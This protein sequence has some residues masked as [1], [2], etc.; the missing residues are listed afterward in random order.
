[1]IIRG[2]HVDRLFVVWD[3]FPVPLADVGITTL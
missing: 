2:G 3:G 1:M